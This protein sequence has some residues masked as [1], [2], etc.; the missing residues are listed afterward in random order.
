MIL[1]VVHTIHTCDDST[2]RFSLTL[3][4]PIGS[5]LLSNGNTTLTSNQHWPRKFCNGGAIDGSR[6]ISHPRS[7]VESFSWGVSTTSVVEL[8]AINFSISRPTLRHTYFVRIILLSFLSFFFLI[9]VKFIR[10]Q[11]PIILIGK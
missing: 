1:L 11:N 5:Y 8:N 2:F 6:L 7:R 3:I 10:S 9:D 4:K